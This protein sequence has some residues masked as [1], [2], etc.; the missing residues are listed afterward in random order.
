MEYAWDEEKSV[1][2]IILLFFSLIYM[3][4]APAVSHSILE[5]VSYVGKVNNWEISSY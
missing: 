5:F 3:Q 4:W 2:F 1:L